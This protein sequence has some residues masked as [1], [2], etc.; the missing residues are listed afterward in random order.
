MS[1]LVAG[2]DIPE[3][4]RAGN[5][6]ANTIIQRSGCTFPPKPSFVWN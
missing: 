2:K 5:Y 1:Q 3:C 6:A 4:V